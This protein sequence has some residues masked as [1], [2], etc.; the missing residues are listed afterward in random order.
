MEA[1]DIRNMFTK[2]VCRRIAQAVAAAEESTSGEIRVV[3]RNRCDADL[4]GSSYRQAVR[5]F[6][7]HGMTKTRERSGV[8]LLLVAEERTLAIVGDTG[9]HA[10]LGDDYW[11]SQIAELKT[12]FAIGDYENGLVAVITAVGHELAT[13]FPKKPDDRDELSNEVVV[14]DDR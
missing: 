2:A 12:R 5:E 10:R 9:I 7:R 11:S 6:E 4:A 14:E 13:H 3:V 1:P 8:L